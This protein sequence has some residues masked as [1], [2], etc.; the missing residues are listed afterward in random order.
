MPGFVVELQQDKLKI[1]D[2]LSRAVAM[3]D[4]N[5]RCPQFGTIAA[6]RK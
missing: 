2:K 4:E 1:S 3:L 5:F 6:R